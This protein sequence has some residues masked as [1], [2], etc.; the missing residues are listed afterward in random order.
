MRKNPD[1]AH[2]C[3]DIGFEM[4]KD[5]G[6]L[7]IYDLYTDGVLKS[8][9]Q[10]KS[11]FNLQQSQFFRYLQFRS[12]INSIPE[13]RTGLCTFPNQVEAILI[14]ASTLPKKTVSFLYES[15]IQVEKAS[16]NNSKVSWENTFE[17]QIEDGV[18]YNILLNAKKITC[19]NKSYETQYKIIH[20]LHI[21]PVI[22]SKYDPLCSPL[23]PRCR[24]GQG[25]HSHM[26][27]TCPKIIPFWISIQDEI[28]KLIG[29]RL[30][31]D[32]L[33]YVLGADIN[34]T[35]SKGNRQ[36]VRALLYAARLSILSKWIDD[37]PPNEVLWYEKVLRLMPLERL[38]CV[39]RGALS[40][41]AEAWRPLAPYIRDEWSN[42]MCIGLTEDTS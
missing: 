19:S 17:V 20:K 42:V 34:S 18:W 22:R 16:T 4:W 27:W 39:L 24:A 9:Q 31:L 5:A 6:I 35:L 41:F 11:E 2:A 32:P 40:D 37:S 38:S 28:L 36:L 12:Y 15:L 8:F 10:L 25:T 23:C 7:T 26:F 13:Y 29:I 1:F 33:H 21:S 14:K 30:P 3:Q